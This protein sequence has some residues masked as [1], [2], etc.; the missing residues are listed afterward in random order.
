MPGEPIQKLLDIMRTLRSPEGCPWDREQTLETLKPY[1]VEEAYEVLDAIESGD[2][3]ALAEELGDL[4]LQIVFQ[5]QL[6]SEEGAFDFDDVVRGISEKLVRRHPHVFGEVKV[7][8]SGEVLKNWEAIKRREHQDEQPSVVGRI[9]RHLPALQKAHQVQKKVS[10]VGFDWDEVHDVMAKLD[11]EVAEVKQAVAAGDA[12]QIREELGDVLFAA[13]NLGRFLGCDAE[14]A[15][16]RTVDKFVRRFQEIERRVHG[17]G[18]ELGQYSLAELD[19]HWN[20][21]KREEKKEEPR[22]DAN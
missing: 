17:Q 15:L 18:K 20:E 3:R 21:I 9:P 19:A 1:L 7:S 10:R 2:R 8:G 11:E 6:C 16:N 13:V 22:I 14:E 4:L 12:G 5:A